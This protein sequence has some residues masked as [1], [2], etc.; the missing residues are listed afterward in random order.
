MSKVLFSSISLHWSLRK[1]LS[2]LAVLWNSAFKWV[3]LSFS[4]LPL[5]F[6]LFSALC[7]ASSDN[8]FSLFAFKTV[9]LNPKW[10]TSIYSLLPVFWAFSGSSVVKNLPANSGSAGDKD[11]IPGSERSPGR[12]NSNWLQYS[13]LGKFTEQRSLAGYSPWGHKEADTTELLSIPHTCVLSQLPLDEITWTCWSPSRYLNYIVV[14]VKRK[15]FP[16]SPK[17]FPLF[18]LPAPTTLPSKFW[19]A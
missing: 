18:S 11:V 19:E 9:L 1:T 6:L 2:L 5:V 3:Y 8:H 16:L 14:K 17:G 7:E 12:G 15:G 4:H 13:G 10:L